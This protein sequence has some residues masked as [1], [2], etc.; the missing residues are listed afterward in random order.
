MRLFTIISLLFFKRII[1]KMVFEKENSVFKY[2]FSH[3]IIIIYTD[4]KDRKQ[5]FG[6]E[7]RVSVSKS[8]SFEI[9]FIV[10]EFLETLCA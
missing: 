10:M 4:P 5:R 2:F 6:S 8:G 7:L 3:L 1:E 9:S